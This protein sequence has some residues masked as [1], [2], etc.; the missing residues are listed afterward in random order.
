MKHGKD[1]SVEFNGKD[2][3]DW[4]IDG[5]RVVRYYRQ[6]SVEVES[7]QLVD[8]LWLV[9]EDGHEYPMYK[10]VGI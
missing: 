6:E 10:P 5:K 7:E 3:N 9:T 1:V 8:V 2:P 4:L